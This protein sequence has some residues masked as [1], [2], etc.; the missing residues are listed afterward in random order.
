MDRD[1]AEGTPLSRGSL[2]SNSMFPAELVSSKNGKT[3]AQT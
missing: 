2:S 3:H 1:A